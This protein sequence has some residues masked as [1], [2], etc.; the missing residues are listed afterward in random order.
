MSD[1]AHYVLM[2]SN[3]TQISSY[4]CCH[5]PVSADLAGGRGLGALLTERVGCE[6]LVLEVVMYVNIV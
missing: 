2:S 3:K 4:V 1:M 6:M 5:C